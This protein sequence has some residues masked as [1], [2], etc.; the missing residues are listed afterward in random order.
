[1]NLI[2]ADDEKRYLLKGNKTRLCF[3][4]QSKWEFRLRKYVN[5][6]G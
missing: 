6:R 4:R 3:L 1:M 2:F 5:I